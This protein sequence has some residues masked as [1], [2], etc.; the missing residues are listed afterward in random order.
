[1]KRGME[2][3]EDSD[4]LGLT[5]PVVILS[6]VLGFTR[7]GEE[8]IVSVAS[9]VLMP[10]SVVRETVDP[11]AAMADGGLGLVGAVLANH[12]PG[13]RALVRIYFAVPPMSKGPRHSGQQILLHFI[14]CKSNLII[15]R[16]QI[17]HTLGL[18]VQLFEMCAS[19]NSRS[20]LVS[21]QMTHSRVWLINCCLDRN[22]LSSGW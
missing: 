19:G 7:T 10:G 22:W 18:C 11:V 21:V 20:V 2:R 9:E 12:R 3:H 5:G 6:D 15:Y 16:R 13:K 17:R 14:V 1:M 8:H 4:C